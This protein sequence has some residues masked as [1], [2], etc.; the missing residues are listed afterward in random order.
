MVMSGYVVYLDVLLLLNFCMDFLLLWT[1]GRALRRRTALWRLLLAAALGGAYASCMVLDLP[2]WLWSLPMAVAVSLQM[3]ALA[4]PYGGGRAFLRL[5][6][7]FYLIACAA[8]GAAL[9]AAGLM[10][11]SSWP[12]SLI[13]VR[14][15]ALLMALPVALIIGRRSYAALRQA[16][17]RDS[18]RARLQVEAA[19][20]RA[21]L[22]ALIDTGN[23]LT[24]PLSGLP[25]VVAEYRA[26]VTLLPERL[27]QAW[28][29]SP[30]RPE[31]VLQ[32]LSDAA[33][34]DG[35]LRRLRLVPFSSIGRRGG[36]MLGFR[37][38]RVV[39]EHSGRRISGQVVVALSSGDISGNG[40]QAVVNPAL[41]E[42]GK[43][44]AA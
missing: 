24:E 19:G 44:G 4:Y 17:N 41:L 20:R 23:D 26:L 2:R 25:V 36:L 43:E 18:F 35:W 38:D 28:N 33:D 32:R 6:G 7:A 1:A 16:W 34:T 30:D 39:L 37:A 29:A 21:A 5:A 10:Q 31:Q 15:A 14:W 3:L 8:A 12:G 42:Q 11:K 22:T 13:S 9:A 27:R 40:Y